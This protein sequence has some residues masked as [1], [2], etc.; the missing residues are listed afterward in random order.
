MLPP[1]AAVPLLLL[2]AVAT[3]AAVW[4]PPIPAV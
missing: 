2:Q 3:R 1:A 4:L